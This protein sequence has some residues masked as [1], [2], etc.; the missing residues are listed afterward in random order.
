MGVSGTELRAA[1]LV[2]GVDIARRG[3]KR[4]SKYQRRPIAPHRRCDTP[5]WASSVAM[6]N[7]ADE[8]GHFTREGLPTVVHPKP[9]RV[10]GNSTDDPC[11]LVSCTNRPTGHKAGVSGWPPLSGSRAIPSKLALTVR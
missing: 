7:A 1:S 4:N 2:P 8:G 10:T 11:L 3:V 6:N 9:A 5:A